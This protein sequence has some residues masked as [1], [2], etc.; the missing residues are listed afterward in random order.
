[1]VTALIVNNKLFLDLFKEKFHEKIDII[2]NEFSKAASLAL[3]LNRKEILYKRAEATLKDKDIVGVKVYDEK[4]VEIISSGGT[5]SYKK[6]Y[7]LVVRQLSTESFF[8]EEKIKNFGSVEIFYTRENIKNLM[9]KILLLSI[10]I[11]FVIMITA[12]LFAYMVLNK[13]FINPLL[14]W[15]ENLENEDKLLAFIKKQKNIMAPEIEDIYNVY[16]SMLHRLKENYQ[17]IVQQKSLAEIG[18]F[19]LTIAHE[20][21]NPLGIIKG[22]IDILKKDTIEP[23]VKRE[24]ISYIEEEVVRIDKLVRG[25]LSMSK[26]VNVTLKEENIKILLDKIVDKSKINFNNI[27]FQ[28]DADDFN[29]NTDA[30]VLSHILE[31]LIKNSVEADSQTI[32]ITARNYNS[33]FKIDL[34]DDGKG[35]KI[36]DCEKIFEPFY[37]TKREG[38]GLGLTFVAKA[39]YQLDGKINVSP[40]DNGGTTFILEFNI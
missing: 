2:G 23:K 11:S 38:S 4:G 39:V 30:E 21:K 25:F 35:I 31:N 15:R 33:I 27:N 36:E 7:P 1:M 13:T 40:A 9:L 28:V 34:T 24:M 3:L 8:D 10:F 6:S 18:K 5:S 26:N 32:K 29:V 20:I 14:F 16:T 22:A 17:K 12:F 37:T 19:S